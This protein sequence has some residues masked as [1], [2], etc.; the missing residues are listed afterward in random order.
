M[1]RSLTLLVAALTFAAVPAQAQFGGLR[2]AA[3]RAKQ[4][5]E[6]KVDKKVDKKVDGKVDQALG[7][8]PSAEAAAAN[9]AGS[10]S[11]SAPASPSAAP[12]EGAWANY[13]FVPGERPLYVNDFGA[14]KVGDFPRRMTFRSGNMQIVEWQGQRW[15]SAEDGALV[16]DLPESLPE[17]FTME[18]DLAGHG[19]AM[20]INF[21][22]DAAGKQPY[23]EI[24]TDF[25]RLRA[26]DVDARGSLVTN[27]GKAPVKIR[28]AVDGD[29]L[30]LYADEQRVL[31]VPNAKLGR[32]KQIF[33]FLNGWSATETRMIANVRVAAGGR[34]MYDALMSDGRVATQGILFDTG[35]DRIRPESTPTLKEMVAMLREHAELKL[36]IEGH[37]DNVGDATA[38]QGLSEKRA[39]AVKAFLVAQ[40]IDGSRLKSAG[41]GAS[42]P[43]AS[44]DTAEGKQQNRRVELVKM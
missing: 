5:V 19:N 4:K 39:A 11:A 18:F 42:K 33:L 38:N 9:P 24:G 25:A 21:A 40:G 13:D 3:E 44:N 28:I 41:F 43:V 26:S 30:K 6:Q 20:Q 12:G 14:D 7:D 2:R 23:V 10:A 36:A 29:Y 27:T 1:V 15:L 22:S 35:S 16:I 37:T 17:R 32:S 31:N 8:G 34:A